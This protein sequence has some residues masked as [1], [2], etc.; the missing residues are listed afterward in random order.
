MPNLYL[1]PDASASNELEI[2]RSRFI[3]FI[4]PVSSREQALELLTR[5]RQQY[6]DARHHCWAYRVGSPRSPSAEAC[7]DDGE[8]Q[9]TAGRPMLNVLQ[10]QSISDVMVVVVRYF[11]GIKLGAGGLIRAYTDAVQATVAKTVLRPRQEMVCCRLRCGYEY[12]AALRHAIEKEDGEW[13]DTVYSAEVEL[14]VSIPQSS[15]ERFKRVSQDIC[16]GQVEF[17]F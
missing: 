1:V 3:G 7:S 6:P 4:E 12:E 11:G 9:G 15:L 8:P 2:K 16:R 10:H 17:Q 13:L 5:L 14:R